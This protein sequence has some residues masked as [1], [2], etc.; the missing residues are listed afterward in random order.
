MTSKQPLL[1]GFSF[2]KNGLTL[3]YPFVES[4]K[5][6]AS[7]CDEVVINVGFDDPNLV[8]DDGTYKLI[9]ENFSSPK[10]KIIKN[11]WDPNVSSKGLILSQQTN[12][13]LKECTGKYC[14]YIQG[15]EV[16]HEDDIELIKSSIQELE[17]RKDCDGLVFQ[18]L[19]FYGNTNIIKRTRN[20]YRREI[21]LIR[22]N[23]K[24]VSWLDAQGFRY[25]DETKIKCLETRARIFH[26]GWARKETIMNDKVKSFS[27]LYHGSNHQNSNFQYQRIWGLQPFKETH[28]S[29]MKDWISLHQND[30][31]IMSLPLDKKIGDL[32]LMISDGI[33]NL[34][35]Y[36]IGEYKN[37]KL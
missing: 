18:Y 1:S 25:Q 20:V 9:C 5:S 23:K 11:W 8:Q 15:D 27:K 7:F 35:G 32:R 26:Y 28:P 10:F 13:A 17:L 36:R 2:I 33:E 16:I 37:F 31:D 6:I 14:Q 19:H 4:I 3:G 34:T 22:N 30:L 29:I 21:R 24:I 12:L